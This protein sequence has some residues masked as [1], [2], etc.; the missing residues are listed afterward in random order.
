[1]PTVR[2]SAELAAAIDEILES[3]RSAVLA[4]VIEI[5]GSAYRRQ[6]AKLVIGSDGDFRGMIS[7]GCL[8]PEVARA[9]SRV[10]KTGQAVTEV[11][12]LTEDAI[13][14][15]RL[16]CGGVVRVLLE[17]IGRDPVWERWL[18]AL[19]NGE[20]AVR[21]VVCAPEPE[22]ESL[23][24]WLFLASGEPPAGPLAREALGREVIPAAREILRGSLPQSRIYASGNA[25]VFLDVNRPPLELVV[26]GA[27]MDAIPVV[28]LALSL[29]FSV[30][31]VDPRPSLNR[32]ERFPGARTTISHPTEFPEKVTM[33]PGS[34]ALIMNHQLDRD[35]AGIRYALESDAIYVGVLGPRPRFRKL[36]DELADDGFRPDAEAMDR[37]HNPVGLDLGAE[38]PEQIAVSILAEILAVHNGFGG[39]FLAARSGGIH[40]VSHTP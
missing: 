33:P 28:R 31:V 35:G 12:D 37:I 39:G 22:P 14:G 36:M 7:G 4:T 6:G 17:P 18:S 19:R 9:A 32:P 13:W 3:G 5:T 24:R 26:F 29:G 2:E 38:G 20:R 23:G 30:K 15:L 11:F 8:E 16:G 1:M 34:Y 27:G 25:R 21:A 10:F 40:E